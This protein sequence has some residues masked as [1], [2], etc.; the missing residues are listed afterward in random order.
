MILDLGNNSRFSTS[1]LKNQAYAGY[2]CF[3]AWLLIWAGLSWSSA[4]LNWSLAGPY[5][6]FSTGLA[7]N[8]GKHFQTLIQEKKL[9]QIEHMTPNVEIFFQDYS[10]TS[11]LRGTDKKNVTPGFMI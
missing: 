10:T 2:L 9:I 7:Q 4:G 6:F 5:A 11:S 8:L 1:L 3:E